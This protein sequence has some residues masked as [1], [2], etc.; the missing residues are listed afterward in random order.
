MQTATLKLETLHLLPGLGDDFDQQVQAM[1]EDCRR[2]PALAKPRK[3]K[4]EIEIKPHPEDSDD[5]LIT[6]VTQVKAPARLI[7]PVRARRSRS[8]QLQ[9]DFSGEIE[10]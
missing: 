5:V 7:D 10:E 8:G 2:R 6:P 9:F 4:L 3:I 1:V